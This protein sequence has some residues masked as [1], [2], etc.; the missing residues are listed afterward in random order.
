MEVMWSSLGSY[1]ATTAEQAENVAIQLASG[2]YY[3]YV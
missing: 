3:R 1:G 2:C